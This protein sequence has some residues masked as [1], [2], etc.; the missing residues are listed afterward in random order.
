MDKRRRTIR[1][2]SDWPVIG[3]FSCPSC[4]AMAGEPCWIKRYLRSGVKIPSGTHKRR[5]LKALHAKQLNDGDNRE[6]AKE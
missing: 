1:D 2:R 4:E 6:R 5:E 3:F